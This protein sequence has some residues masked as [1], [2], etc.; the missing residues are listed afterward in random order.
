MLDWN[1]NDVQRQ[2]TTK[3]H[4]VYPAVS[5]VSSICPWFY[6]LQVAVVSDSLEEKDVVTDLRG[7]EGMCE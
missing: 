3:S 1:E 4:D 7:K 6:C 2:P 5:K